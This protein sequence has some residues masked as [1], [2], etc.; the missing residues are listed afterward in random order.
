MKS[1]L[2][3]SIIVLSGCAPTKEVHR[4]AADF[5]PRQIID[6]VNLRSSSIATFQAKG[7]ISVESPS[8]IN[9]GSFELWMKKPDSVRVDIG[10]PFGI[11]VASALFARDHYIFYN[12]F[13]NEVTEGDVDS[14]D[15][16]AFMN[17][18]VNPDDILDTFSGTR[19]F[20]PA[21][22]SPDSFAFGD[23][24]YMLQFEHGNGMTRYTVD[25]R[26]LYITAIEHIDSTG[27][28]WSEERYD[29]ER[30]DDGTIVPQSVRLI[31]DRLESSV[32]VQYQTVHINVPMSGL[33]IEIPSD[34]HRVTKE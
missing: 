3:F 8:F 23:G 10:G 22:T 15:M 7:S 17:F 2:F 26:T 6:A 30:H 34:A 27:A 13:K 12:S 19:G 14:S 28:V 29:F 1:L 9:S 31:H 5:T 21:E 32:S 20:F 25:G 33:A 16:P 18:R 4:F 11:R 24:S